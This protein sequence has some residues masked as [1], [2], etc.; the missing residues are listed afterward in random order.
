MKDFFIPFLYLLIFEISTLQAQIT[1]TATIDTIGGEKIKNI[2]IGGYIDTYFAYDVNKP[3]DG[4]IPYM[5]SSNLHNSFS[6]NLAYI[7]LRYNTPNIRARLVP[8]FGSYMNANYN[9]E[10][11]LLKNLVESSVGIKLHKKKEIWIE[12][13]IFGSPFT[14]ESAISKD[15]F[16]Y[17]RSLAPEYVPYYL[18][19]VKTSFPINNKI[20]FYVYILN[21]WQQIQD[22]NNGK[23]I[24]TQI[25]YRPNQKHLINW[26]TYIGDE[27]SKLNPTFRN[28]YFTDV[29]WLFNVSDKFNLISCLYGGLQETKTTKLYNNYWW[30]MNLSSKW[31]FN[32]KH[33]I[34]ARIEYFDDPSNCMI[35]NQNVGSKV[36]LY[37]LG[38]CYNLNLLNHVLF[39][40][41]TRYFGSTHKTFLHQESSNQYSN[42][43][44]TGNITVWF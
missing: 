10:I 15:H 28:R 26:N 7:D 35:T 27:R 17:T 19:G 43:V 37:S 3:K 29:Y 4:L 41:D 2:T 24:A 21:G 18:A 13:G 9:N 11:G 8:G 25:E 36:K 38:I 14:N 39:R 30:Q 12:S 42:S 32:E 23:S 6:V 31:K 33:S 40:I 34:A 22:Q 5:V 1:N 44:I 20:N 16:M